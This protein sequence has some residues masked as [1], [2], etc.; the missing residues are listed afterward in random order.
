M[1]T[2][3]FGSTGMLGTYA[4]KYLPY[5]VGI[6]REQVNALIIQKEH[7]YRQLNDLFIQPQDVI[8]NCMGI[9]NKYFNSNEEFIIV[10]SLFPRML[11]DYCE[12]KGAKMI[13]ITTDCVFSGAEG[14]YCE[15]DLHD[16]ENIYGLSKSVGEPLNCTTIRTSIVGENRRNSLDLLEWVRKHKDT[17]INGWTNHL[18]NGITCLQFAKLC[19]KIIRTKAFWLGT[20]HIYSPSPITKADMVEFIS[21]LYE[22]N[23]VINKIEASNSCDRT[24]TSIYPTIFTIPPIGKQLIEQKEFKI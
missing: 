9:T 23:N 20:R 4:H 14:N 7:F 6:T 8:I 21:D 19:E 17:T 24:L 2:F 22:L 11:A 18:W 15:T 12:E 1:K 3:I 13:H 16:D 10:N 5:S